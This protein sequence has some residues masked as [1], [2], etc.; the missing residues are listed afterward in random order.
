MLVVADNNVYVC[1]FMNEHDET[2]ITTKTNIGIVYVYEIFNCFCCCNRPEYTPNQTI[3]AS[4]T[5]CSLTVLNW[6]RPRLGIFWPRPFIPSRP[7][8][9]I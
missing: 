2:I 4:C 3:S 9:N 5:H 7:Y 6:P 1:R 8:C